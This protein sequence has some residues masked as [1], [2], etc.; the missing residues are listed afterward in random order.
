MPS[1][2]SLSS[3]RAKIILPFASLANVRMR[4][5]FHKCQTTL[6]PFLV[7]V[8]SSAQDRFCA[9]YSFAIVLQRESGRI[10]TELFLLRELET[11]TKPRS[12]TEKGRVWQFQMKAF[13]RV[14]RNDQI[15]LSSITRKETKRFSLRQ[16]LARCIAFPRNHDV[17]L[18]LCTPS[19][20]RTR[21]TDEKQNVRPRNGENEGVSTL[22]FTLLFLARRG[23]KCRT[24]LS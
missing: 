22:H 5:F 9:G 15:G 6:S 24:R 14:L 17:V 8:S 7:L 16:R 23:H 19:S 20:T 2:V 13:V 21:L 1:E 3:H 4:H 11:R 12:F 18:Q 10:N